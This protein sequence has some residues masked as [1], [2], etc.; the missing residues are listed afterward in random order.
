M[1][2]KLCLGIFM[3]LV[4]YCSFLRPSTLIKVFQFLSF[5]VSIK[6][7]LSPKSN[8]GFIWDGIWV[9]LSC[10]SIITMKE[11]LLK[12]TVVSFL[13]KLIFN[14]VQGHF[15]ASIKIT[16][17]KTLRRNDTTWNF[18]RSITRVS[19]LF[20]YMLPSWQTAS[21]DPRVRPNRKA[22]GAVHY[23]SPAC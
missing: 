9:K 17:F 1:P 6:V 12:F 19:T 15:Y 8:Q 18:A 11:V 16:I 23:Y 2:L 21:V 4:D 13:G 20:A 5:K 14:G 3:M 7:N 10:K 22:W